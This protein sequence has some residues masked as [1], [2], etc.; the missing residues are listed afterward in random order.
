MLIG[1]SRFNFK[2]VNF[3]SEDSD[4][5]GRIAFQV[6]EGIMDELCESKYYLSQE[7]KNENIHFLKIMFDED[8]PIFVMVSSEDLLKYPVAKNKDVNFSKDTHLV[9]FSNVNSYNEYIK[10]YRKA[11]GEFFPDKKQ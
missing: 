8:N 4:N 7:E 5:F 3:S 9:D 11:V 1:K 2:H 10:I 6:D